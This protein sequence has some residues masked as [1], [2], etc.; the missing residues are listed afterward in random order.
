MCQI[1]REAK[2]KVIESRDS[3]TER[4]QTTNLVS[5]SQIQLRRF[6]TRALG[7]LFHKVDND[8]TII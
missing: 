2:T 6:G 7:T 1:L 3:Q 5:V 4:A 8:L